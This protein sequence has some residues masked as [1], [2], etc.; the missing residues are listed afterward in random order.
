MVLEIP[1][2]PK[3][4][5]VAT[6]WQENN[7][8]QDLFS[9]IVSFEFVCLSLLFAWVFHSGTAEM[10]EVVGNRGKIKIDGKQLL[11]VKYDHC[12]IIY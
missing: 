5:V 1:A 9:S 8:I 2:V 4:R 3:S 11:R 6:K 10:K 7:K 12:I